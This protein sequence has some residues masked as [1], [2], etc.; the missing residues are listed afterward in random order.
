M[1]KL[2]KYKTEITA[3]IL[4]VSSYLFL[5]LYNIMSLP[6]FTDESI[7]VR[8]S[9]IARYDASWR[10]ISLTDGKQPSFVW[11]TM[12]VMRFIEDPLLAG[13]LVS[14]LAGLVTMIG[15]YF[16][17]RALFKNKWIGI[18]S[19]FLYLI[20]PMALVYDR[21]ALYDSLVGTFMVWSLYFCVLLVRTVRLDVALILGMIIGGGMLTKTSAFFSAPLLF[22]TYLIFDWKQKA[23]MRLFKLIGLSLLSVGMAFGFYSILRLSPFYHIINDKNSLFAYPLNE[24][25]QHPTLYFISNLRGL[26]DWT[27]TYLTP[28]VFMIIIASFIVAGRWTRKD[29]MAFVKISSPFIAIILVLNVLNT[30]R[31]L[32]T[33]GVEIQTLLPYVFFTL[34]F[35]VIWISI[36][37]KHDFWK[38]KIV[39]FLWFIVPFV[40][41][42]F[43]GRTLYPRFIFFMLL[44]L[45]PL[46]AFSIFG[47]FGFIK[48]KAILFMVILLIIAMSLYSNF[49]IVTNIAAAPIP[50]SDYEQYINNWPAGGGTE[51]IISYLKGESKK[52]KIYVAS[53]GTFGS[54]PTYAVEIYLGDNRNV[55]KR[56]IY[57][58]P[59][60][61]P[62]DLQETA[63]KMPVFLFVSNQKEFEEAIENWPLALIAQYRKGSGKAYSMLYRVNP[64]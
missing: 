37:R 59:S 3:A 21:M 29:L 33:P 54:L 26:F 1:L 62:E 49:F 32:K 7:Y 15:L 35:I 13:R 61:I 46:A 48:N 24:W 25:L 28:P 41:L 17:G 36:V 9:Q 34:M 45:L 30:L 11:L 23:N 22:A 12:T 51:E 27:L 16:L 60:E 5:R 44:P 58:V 50:R 31:Y 63:K 18:I 57:P 20:F 47:L 38:E 52:G 64:K 8:W 53:L 10:F 39:L 43:F 55:E 19:S 56:G 42:A 2:G 14:V 40:Y 4:L 6:L